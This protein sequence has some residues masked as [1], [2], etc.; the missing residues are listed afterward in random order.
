M[1]LAL[2]LLALS[3]LAVEELR[4]GRVLG[5]AR[6]PCE[7]FGGKYASAQARC[8]TRA[9]YWFD[10]CGYWAAP[11]RWRDRIVFGDSIA[12]VMFWLGQP[13]GVQDDTYSWSYGKGGSGRLFTATFRDG[14][15]VAWKDDA[16]GIGMQKQ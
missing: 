14:R 5:L 13:N 3:F 7:F 15:F 1:Y 11:S 12:T 8:V 2:G 6:V 16:T 9:C 10:D 4:Y